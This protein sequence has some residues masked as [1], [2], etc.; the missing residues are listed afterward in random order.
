MK[1]NVYD[2]E[3]MSVEELCVKYNSTPNAIRRMRSY[4]QIYNR[5]TRIRIISPFK[6]TIVRSIQECCDTLDLSRT[7]IKRALNGEHVPI[8][9]EMGIRLEVVK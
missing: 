1:Y 8:L 2:L 4:H 7:T 5:K 9:E 3:T 6:I